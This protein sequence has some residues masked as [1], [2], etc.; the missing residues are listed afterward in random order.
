MKKM[1]EE[2]MQ[3]L[4]IEN[5]IL[6]EKSGKSVYSRT[7]RNSMSQNRKTKCESEIKIVESC[8]KSLESSATS[9]SKTI[10]S[11]ETTNQSEGRSLAKCK[12]EE[13]KKMINQHY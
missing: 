2:K 10:N 4:E 13:R 9:S 3:A 11:S 12:E 6:K 5:N 8:R 1:F 7:E